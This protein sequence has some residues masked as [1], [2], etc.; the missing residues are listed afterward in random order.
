[1]AKAKI[2]PNINPTNVITTKTAIAIF[3]ITHINYSSPFYTD[4]IPE[5]PRKAKASIPAKIN[6][7]PSPS[8]AL[9]TSASLNFSLKLAISI[10]AKANPKPEPTADTVLSKNEKL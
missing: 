2:K 10:I 1:M 7:M 3:N 8:N 6:A 5:N 4:I 9:G